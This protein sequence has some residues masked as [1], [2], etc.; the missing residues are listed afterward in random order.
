MSKI[1][2]S[3]R[4]EY[5]AFTSFFDSVIDRLYSNDNP[6]SEVCKYVLSGKGKRIRPLLC[7]LTHSSFK[8]DLRA[9][10]PSAAALEF[11][12]TYSLV[13]DDLPAMDDDDLRR[14]QPTAHKKFNEAYAILAGDGILA[15]AFRV[16]AD[17]DFS[18]LDANIK[19][20]LVQTL[21]KHAGS[22]GMVAG[23]AWDLHFEN[24]AG[25]DLES[26]ERIHRLKTG[27][28]MGA[29]MAMGAISAGA[30][31]KIS[32]QYFS[33]GI[34]LGLVFQLID[35]LLDDMPDTGKS[36]GKDKEMGKLTY[37]S[38][39]SREKCESIA[40][41]MTDDVF[42]RLESIEASPK[43]LELCQLLCQRDR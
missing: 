32:D 39:Y 27:H 34:D 8:S 10:L 29:S 9:A 16:L 36:Q 23:Q 31:D 26:L 22:F 13:H 24:K 7:L 6:V 15:D 4:E 1:D 33:I 25:K 17:D 38:F 40:Q 12:H 5:Q 2:A 11:I 42:K 21:A 14:G 37:L 43:L 35:D 28:L 19:M 41:E 3:Y 30:S 18:G 20:K